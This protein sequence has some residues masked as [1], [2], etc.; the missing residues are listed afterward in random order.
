MSFPRTSI[1]VAAATLLFG[2]VASVA[3]TAPSANHGDGLVT[4]RAT[5][6]QD[7][8]GRQL[9]AEL[10]CA[11]C[12]AGVATDAETAR[13]RF[14]YEELFE[15]PVLILGI[16]WIGIGFYTSKLTFQNN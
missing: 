2:G 5:G 11:A 14:V 9:V 1:R 12:H 13:E 6:R 4:S 7:D 10:G 16:A 8:A 3:L 15:L